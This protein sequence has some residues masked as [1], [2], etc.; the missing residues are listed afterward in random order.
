MGVTREM[1]W[2]EIGMKENV[3]QLLQLAVDDTEEKM[4]N[5]RHRLYDAISDAATGDELQEKMDVILEEAIAEFQKLRENLKN[6]VIFL[7]T[8]DPYPCDKCSVVL[9]GLDPNEHCHGC[10]NEFKMQN[11]AGPGHMGYNDGTE[12]TFD[13]T[14]DDKDHPGRLYR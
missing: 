6:P 11:Y 8:E 1:L 10:I 14:A 7:D 5:I 4:Q 13:D 2:G 3:P 12:M 9:K